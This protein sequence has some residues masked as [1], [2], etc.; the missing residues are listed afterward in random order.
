[1]LI[2][3]WS[4]QTPLTRAS[5]RRVSPRQ[6]VEVGAGGA[7]VGVGGTGVGVG[8]GGGV[9]VGG[10]GGGVGGTGVGVGGGGGVAWAPVEE[11][12]WGR[13]AVSAPV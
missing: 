7:G 10:G 6:G 12:A 8:G 2:V 9:G 5:E 11:S 1:M 3:P 13:A 4:G